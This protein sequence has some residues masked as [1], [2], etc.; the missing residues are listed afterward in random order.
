ML[1]QQNITRNKRRFD[2]VLSFSM[3]SSDPFHTGGLVVGW[4]LSRPSSPRSRSHMWQCW[5]PHRLRYGHQGN[6]PNEP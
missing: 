3:V 4:S 2:A 1:E 5:R 6:S